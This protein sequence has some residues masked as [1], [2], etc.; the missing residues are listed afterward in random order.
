M[1]SNRLLGLVVAIVLGIFASM[2]VYRQFQR[3]LRRSP[4]W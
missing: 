4:S 1:N 2:F 3:L